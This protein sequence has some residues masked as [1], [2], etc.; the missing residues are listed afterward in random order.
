MDIFRNKSDDTG[1]GL[2]AL[3][4]ISISLVSFG[5]KNLRVTRYNL[6]VNYYSMRQ[7]YKTMKIRSS[8]YVELASL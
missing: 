1:P 2:T 3:T 8:V 7:N 4:V 6:K 5:E